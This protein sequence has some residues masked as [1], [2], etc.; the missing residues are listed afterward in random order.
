MLIELFDTQKRI[1][2]K[3]LGVKKTNQRLN[4]TV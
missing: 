3:V 1:N 2:W 4:R